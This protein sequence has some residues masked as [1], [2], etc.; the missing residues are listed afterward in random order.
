MRNKLVL[1][2]LSL[3]IFCSCSS[4]AAQ[5]ASSKE[6]Q[7]L[8]VRALQTQLM[9]AAIGC[10]QQALYNN[11]V[12]KYGK[13]LVSEGKVIKA[14]FSRTYPK[15]AESELNRFVTFLAN[16]SSKRSLKQEDAAFCAASES[17]FLTLS[18]SQNSSQFL[19]LASGAPYQETHG[20]RACK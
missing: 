3:A 10:N 14:Y 1:S 18:K 17:L 15:R 20:I 9:V 13:S 4:Q 5:C 2:V 19:E 12:G 7:A 6:L 16:E 8:N 11:F